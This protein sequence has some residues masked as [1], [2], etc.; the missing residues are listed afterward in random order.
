MVTIMELH[1]LSVNLQ[2]I[3]RA[4]SDPLLN[5]SK[6]YNIKFLVLFPIL[7]TM[8]TTIILRHPLSWVVGMNRV[9]YVHAIA[10]NDNQVPIY[11]QF[12]LSIKLLNF[13]LAYSFNNLVLALLLPTK[14][15]VMRILAAQVTIIL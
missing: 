8:T 2:P 4:M 9:I 12:I 15:I 7:A 13:I 6:I 5:L 10:I 11:Q 14:W 3:I 1:Q